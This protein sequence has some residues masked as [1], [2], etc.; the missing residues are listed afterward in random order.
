MAYL[1]RFYDP[2][3]DR[4]S[5]L[6]ERTGTTQENI[7]CPVAAII[8][9]VKAEG[10]EAL[11]R[12]TEEFD[13][14]TL[15]SL[16]IPTSE[17]QKAEELVDETLKKALAVAKANIEAFH[18]AQSAEGERLER[19]GIALWR[20]I[21]P[22]DRVGLYVP[23]G[24]APL[25]STVLMLAIP[26]QVAGCKEIV[27]CTPPDR[28]GRVNPAIL[29]AAQLCGVNEIYRVGGAQ[30]IG[31]MATGT[32]SIKKVDKIYG[33]GNR[34][35]TEAKTQVGSALCAIDLPAGPSEVMVVADSFADPVFVA[36][37]LLSQAEHGP[38]SQAM[39]I[40]CADR[41]DGELYADAVEKAIAEQLK[42]LERKA[43]LEAS[44][45]NSRLFIIPS[46]E[47]CARL[48]NAYASEH[49]IINLQNEKKEEQLLSM[50]TN[51]GSIFLGPWSPE[52]SGD[53]ASGTNHTLPT[54]GWARGYSGLSTDSFIKK[55][56]VQRLSRE[57]L[58]NLAP[59]LAAMA[60][61]EGLK[62]HRKAVDVRL[63]EER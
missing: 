9:A 54:G 63:G 33:P 17:I 14:V 8:A 27:L 60:D 59:T 3:E 10:D 26:A 45:A 46:L 11:L 5:E 1:N 37:D 48:A 20:K 52:S 38:D 39:L 36:S 24:S 34:W 12:F 42:Q 61:A 28:E 58:E 18:Q 21:V 2:P 47:G 13:K 51:A 35:V 31:A 44:L 6:L 32:A 15:S 43:A 40:I 19:E 62:A 29:Y 22:I 25:I 4:F 56:T 55:I 23:G 16:R 49:L 41:E 53:Y 50:I 57:G 7:S 30:A